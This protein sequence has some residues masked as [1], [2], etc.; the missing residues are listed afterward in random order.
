MIDYFLEQ[1]PLTPQFDD[2]RRVGSVDAMAEWLLEHSDLLTANLTEYGDRDK[3][4]IRDIAAA[5]VTYDRG[6]WFAEIEITT[7]TYFFYTGCKRSPYHLL[8][9]TGLMNKWWWKRNRQ[10]PYPQ[11]GTS[12]PL[13][14]YDGYWSAVVPAIKGTSIF[15]TS[16]LIPRELWPTLYLGQKLITDQ[17]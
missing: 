10:R 9:G 2:L 4:S 16:V 8:R 12:A 15:R 3:L 5:R 14:N 6:V 1:Q 13:K 7:G 17:G 11:T